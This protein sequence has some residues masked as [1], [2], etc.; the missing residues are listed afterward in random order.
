[1]PVLGVGEGDGRTCALVPKRSLGEKGPLDKTSH[2]SPDS[3]HDSNPDVG[4]EGLLFLILQ[5]GDRMMEASFRIELS[6]WDQKWDF[7]LRDGAWGDGGGI[8][9]VR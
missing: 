3:T 5:M 6:G 4:G 1:M 8:L 2:C 7:R 9:P